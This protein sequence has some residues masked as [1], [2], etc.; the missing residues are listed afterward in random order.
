MAAKPKPQIQ[1]PTKEALEFIHKGGSVPKHIEA[2]EEPAES[3]DVK[4]AYNVPIYQSQ[5][6]DIKSIIESMPERKRP[7][8]RKY[9]AEAIEQ[10]IERDKKISARKQS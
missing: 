2:R 5:I 7:S 4:R 10:R 8:L 3:G 9:L 1:L 6:D